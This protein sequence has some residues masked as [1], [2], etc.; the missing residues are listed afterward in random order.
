LNN[1]KAILEEAGSQAE[2]IV[3]ANI[4][5][6]SMDHYAAVNKAYLEFFSWDP[7]PVGCS[8]FS[9]IASRNAN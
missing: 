9:H 4:F 6:S 2:N 1:L 7:K 8:V 3:K 5:L